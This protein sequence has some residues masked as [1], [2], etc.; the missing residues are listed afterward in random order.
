MKKIIAKDDASRLPGP[1][2]DVPVSNLILLLLKK[3]RFFHRQVD[4]FLVLVFK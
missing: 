3:C 1:K 4:F 2:E